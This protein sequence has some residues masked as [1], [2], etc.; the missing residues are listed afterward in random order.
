MLF[1]LSKNYSSHTTEH[2]KKSYKA[3]DKRNNCYQVIGYESEGKGRN[4]PTVH[5]I[6]MQTFRSDP[7]YNK[8]LGC[9]KT[10]DV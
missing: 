8:D 1:S 4:L 2:S 7:Q 5:A 9:I 3:S 10:K 6:F